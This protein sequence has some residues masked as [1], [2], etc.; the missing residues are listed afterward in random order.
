[1]SIY[2]EN[3]VTYRIADRRIFPMAQR[4]R[5]DVY[6]DVGYI[7]SPCESGVI[8]DYKD[9]F[10]EY[11]TAI[12]HSSAEVIGTMRLTPLAHSLDL[13][14]IWD[15]SMFDDSIE[16]MASA[17]NKCSVELGALAVK[18]GITNGRKV[19]WGLYKATLLYS[20]TRN[21]D[22]WVIAMDDRALRTLEMLGWYVHRI[23][24]SIMYMGSS[25]TLG[26][27]PVQEQLK[28]IAEKNQVFYKF[29][30]A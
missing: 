5:H 6:L 24:K 2:N 27:M 28:S 26:I 17:K 10:S 11:I 18:K 9:Y 7:E 19:S 1:M 12:D 22:Y 23:G 30:S 16:Y 20:L 14:E 8:M 3:G 15:G 25:T 13:F 4:L 21:F 29:I